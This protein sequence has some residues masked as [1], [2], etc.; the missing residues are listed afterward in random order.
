MRTLIPRADAGIIPSLREG[1][2]GEGGTLPSHSQGSRGQPKAFLD[3]REFEGN[4][5]T[6]RSPL[7]APDLESVRGPPPSGKGPPR[8]QLTFVQGGMVM[9]KWQR[10]CWASSYFMA[11]RRN[12]KD[13]AGSRLLSLT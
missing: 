3:L 4:F 1:L 8:G 11:L 7:E 9:F 5:S 10:M 12:D 6:G 13:P 2:W